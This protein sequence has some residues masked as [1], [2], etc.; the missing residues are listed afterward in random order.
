[1]WNLLSASVIGTSHARN[2]TPCQDAHR[3][4]L[5]ENGPLLIAT[6]DGAGTADRSQAGA[7]LSV[8]IALAFLEG[9]LTTHL[10][11]DEPGWERLLTEAFKQA[12]AAV[13]ALADAE[14]L[15]ARSFACTLTLVIVT[16]DWLVTGQIGDGVV[17][18]QTRSGELITVAP[19][20]RGEYANE[21][22]FLIADDA[23]TNFDGRIYRQHETIEALSALA[24]M[25][26]GL[27][28]LALDVTDHRPHAPFF[29]PLLNFAATHPDPKE[30]RDQLHTFLASPRVNARTDDDKTLVLAARVDGQ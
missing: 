8:E 30:A 22:H 4:T 5:M 16:D 19:P 2:N 23:L 27:L 14:C 11:T 13:F 1:M 18:A 15:P 26:D 12:R 10:P 28:R 7:T 29:T 21:T 9:A 24:V 25:T 3:W 17:V 20:Q 6:A